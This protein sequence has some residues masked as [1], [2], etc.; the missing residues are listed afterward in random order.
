MLVD[1]KDKQYLCG[2]PW[3]EEGLNDGAYASDD[4]E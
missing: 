4:D 3:K 1:I 2:E